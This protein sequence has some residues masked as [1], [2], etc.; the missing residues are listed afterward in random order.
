M[1][2][3]KAQKKAENEAARKAAKAQQKEEKTEERA[4]KAA[5]AA[6]ERNPL[7]SKTP[8][9][10]KKSKKAKTTTEAGPSNPK[11][12][13]C[14]APKRGSSKVDSMKDSMDQPISSKANEGA[15][16]G[17]KSGRGKKSTSSMWTWK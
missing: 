1:V 9:S 17:I 5:A 4:A 15:K 2:E 10:E 12:K 8:T 7:S 6:K 14:M 13:R 3:A 11:L 16:F